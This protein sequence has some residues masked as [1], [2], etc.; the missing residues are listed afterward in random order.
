[1]TKGEKKYRRSELYEHYN[2]DIRGNLEEYEEIKKMR[3]E[4]KKRRKEREEK[5]KEAKR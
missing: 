5:E 3:E 1:M 2:D 4:I